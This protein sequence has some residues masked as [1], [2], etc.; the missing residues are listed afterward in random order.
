MIEER[1]DSA[2]RHKF[3]VPESAMDGNG[4]VNNVVYV[5]WMQDVA[6]LHSDA[7]GGTEA[8]LAAGGSGWFALESIYRQKETRHRRE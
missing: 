3:T 4:H 7:V 8:A 2:Y 6:I 1:S 5:Q